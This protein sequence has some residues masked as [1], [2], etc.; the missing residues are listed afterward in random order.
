MSEQQYLVG[1]TNYEPPSFSPL[2]ININRCMNWM[3]RKCNVFESHV[4]VFLGTVLIWRSAGCAES[5][6]YL[7]L[8]CLFL[9]VQ[10]W[11]GAVLDVP[12][13]YRICVSCACFC[14]YS[15]DLAPC[16]MFRKCTVFVSH[17]LFFVGT[18][19]IWR[20][21]GCSESVPYLCLM[22][23]FLSVQF[24]SGALLDVPK[25]YRIYVLCA[26]F[27]RYSSDL[28]PCWMCRKCTVFMSHVLVFV[29]TVL[30]GRRA[31]FPGPLQPPHGWLPQVASTARATA[32][33]VPLPTPCGAGPWVHRTIW[34]VPRP[35]PR[36]VPAR[37]VPLDLLATADS[38]FV[39]DAGSGGTEQ[40]WGRP[41]TRKIA[42]RLRCAQNA[43]YF[44][45]IPQLPKIMDFEGK[46]SPIRNKDCICNK[47]IKHVYC[48]KFIGYYS[49]VKVK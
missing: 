7:C 24:W 47:A 6:P 46:G 30:I 9:S 49:L 19:L 43:L 22:C 48:F 3:C 42:W 29:G 17:V 26:C 18:V 32:P 5:V 36:R 12:K 1:S 31:G 10:F 13:V 11:S 25:V 21:A 16:W 37:W 33:P 2:S 8:M 38:E 44:K 15:S 4:L 14:R 45:T 28:A 39:A 27:C 41:A 40:L 35:G 20:R 34:A 23:L